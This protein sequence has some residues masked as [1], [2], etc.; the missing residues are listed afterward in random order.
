[1]IIPGKGDRDLT[2]SQRLLYGGLNREDFTQGQLL[3]ML[4]GE[5][6]IY[7]EDDVSD[8][9]RVLEILC[10]Q[11]VTLVIVLLILPLSVLREEW[12]VE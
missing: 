9:L 12:S 2:V 6:A 3:R 11:L 4:G 7:T 5:A 8:I 1:L 10:P